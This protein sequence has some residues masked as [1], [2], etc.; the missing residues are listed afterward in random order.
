MG[1]GSPARPAPLRSPLGALAARG[2]PSCASAPGCLGLL[3]PCDLT[4][5][6]KL[7]PLSQEMSLQL[8]GTQASAPPSHPFYGIEASGMRALDSSVRQTRVPQRFVCAPPEG[9]PSPGLWTVTALQLGGHRRTSLEQILWPCPRAWGCL[10][11]WPNGLS[12][13]DWK[14][15]SPAVFPKALAH[16]VTAADSSRRGPQVSQTLRERALWWVAEIRHSEPPAAAGAGTGVAGA[17]ALQRMSA[18]TASDR[19]P[20]SCPVT[21]TGPCS[22]CWCW[23]RGH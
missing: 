22:P 5:H 3:L 23:P 21:A 4:L 8:S 6:L 15:S 12:V 10:T 20:G 14:C 2:A 7:E 1:P 13:N 17:A 9:D 18:Q 16:R 19:R 11:T